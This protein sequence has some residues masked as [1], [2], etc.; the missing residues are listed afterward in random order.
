MPAIKFRGIVTLGAA[1]L[2][3]AFCYGYQAESGGTSG[4]VDAAP[5]STQ[6]LRA[7]AAPIAL[8]PDPLVAQILAAST[9][10]DQVAVASYWLQQNKNLTGDALLGA[11]NQQHWDASVKA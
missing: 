7:L 8:Y 2:I 9:F 6:K 4:V 3:A 5:V 10:P 11:V 1:V